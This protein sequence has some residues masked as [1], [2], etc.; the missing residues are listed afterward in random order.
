[1]RALPGKQRARQILARRLRRTSGRAC[2]DLLGLRGPS[3]NRVASVFCSSAASCCSSSWVV[4]PAAPPRPRRRGRAQPPAL[5][6]AAP[7]VDGGERAGRSP[8]RAPRDAAAVSAAGARSVPLRPRA[9]SRAAPAATSRGRSPR[10]R[11]RRPRPCCRVWSRSSRPPSTASPH[12]QARVRRRRRRA[13]AQGRR[14]D[15]PLR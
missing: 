3:C 15:R 8:A 2:Y 6:Q 12:S 9:R 14:H 4:A 11:R 5:D 7:V 1:M 13:D 10:H